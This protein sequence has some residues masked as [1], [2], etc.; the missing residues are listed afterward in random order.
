MGWSRQLSELSILS[1]FRE[2]FQETRVLAPKR[3]FLFVPHVA[4]INEGMTLLRRKVDG[5]GII[6]HHL[7]HLLFP[8]APSRGWK[9]LSFEPDDGKL[10]PSRHWPPGPVA[11]THWGAT[12]PKSCSD[13]LRPSGGGML[14][15]QQAETRSTLKWTKLGHWVWS[16][17]G[18]WVWLLL[19][20]FWQSHILRL[21]FDTPSGT[22]LFLGQRIMVFGRRLEFIDR[23]PRSRPAD[24]QA[25][26]QLTWS[27]GAGGRPNYLAADWFVLFL[28]SN[29]EK[30]MEKTMT[31]TKPRRRPLRS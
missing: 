5:K 17:L 3:T 27:R 23:T 21:C 16:K 29:G 13:S 22:G 4:T 18:Y 11:A 20:S 24:R 2:N 31:N 9:Q 25:K 30:D 6:R 26:E 19:A 8:A 28:S 1:F 10:R 7:M 15:E 12:G 14:T